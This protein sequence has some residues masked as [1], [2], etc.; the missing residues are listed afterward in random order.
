VQ[1]FCEVA[2]LLLIVFAFVVVGVLSVRRVK[3]RLLGVDAASAAA[4]TGRGLRLQMVGTTAVVFV[5]FVIRSVF[6]TFVAVAYAS[7]DLGKE[8]D[9]RCLEADGVCDASCYNVYTQIVRWMNYTPEFEAIIVLVS[10]PLAL[11]VA[12]W[13]MTPKSTLQLMESSRQESA[14]SLRLQVHQVQ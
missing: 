3:S 10:S 4:A 8:V 12:L 9:Q 7:R 6:S 13:G 1:R 5:A 14:I 2:V 11:L